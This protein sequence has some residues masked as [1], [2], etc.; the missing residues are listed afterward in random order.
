MERGAEMKLR[1]LGFLF[2]I[3]IVLIAAAMGC[4]SKEK[5]QKEEAS[6]DI[7]SQEESFKE[8]DKTIERVEQE[9][10]LDEYDN[11]IKGEKEPFV[12]R[13]FIDKNIDELK[14]EKA[15]GMLVKFEEVQEDYLKRYTEEL[16]TEGYQVELLSLSGFT[17]FDGKDGDHVMDGLFFDKNRIEEIK[18]GDLKELAE[19][20]IDGKYKLINMEGAF[21]PTIDYEALKDYNEYISEEIKDYIHIQAMDSNSPS[22]LDAELK[23]TFEELG[24]RIIDV[25]DYI[26]KYPL[27]KK[28]D[29]ALSLYGTYLYAYI[30]GTDNSPIYEYQTSKIKDEVLH[31]YKKVIDGKDNK[32]SQMLVEYMEIIK[33]NKNK[34]D[35]SVLS[36]GLSLRKQ[37]ISGLK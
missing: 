1:K 17:Q 36:K 25:E 34:I 24:D 33:E 21:Y 10:I 5:D 11:M 32:T 20:L 9:D 35:D 14:E 4:K 6:M 12:L 18:N 23:I 26:E 16:F 28:H 37:A 2:I 8:E 22:V 27:S 13:E 15:T 31:S 19:Q 3:G 29:E 30:A 7:E